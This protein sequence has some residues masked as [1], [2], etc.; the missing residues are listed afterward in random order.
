MQGLGV[1]QH[2]RGRREVGSAAKHRHGATG[3][4]DDAGGGADL[5]GIEQGEGA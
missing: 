1:E 5:V 4:R 3:S 2:A